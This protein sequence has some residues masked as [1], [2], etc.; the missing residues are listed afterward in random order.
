MRTTLFENPKNALI[1]GGGILL[2][3]VVLIGE[4]NDEGALVAAAASNHAPTPAF[5]S[6]SK[7]GIREYVPAGSEE[8]ADSGSGWENDGD[9]VDDADGMDT[10]PTDNTPSSGDSEPS[11]RA[12]LREQPPGIDGPGT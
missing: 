5:A 1:F 12:S 6:G 7:A 9:L 10:S 8:E 3:A 11:T 2:A 4:E